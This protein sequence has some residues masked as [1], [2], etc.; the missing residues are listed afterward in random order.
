MAP[1]PFKP[2]IAGMF[3]M[4]AV[5]AA[6]LFAHFIRLAEIEQRERREAFNRNAA[7]EN[8]RRWKERQKATEEKAQAAAKIS[9]ARAQERAALE[10]AYAKRQPFDVG[11]A[12]GK[13]RRRAE[14][15][16]PDAQ[17][18]MGYIHLHG[19]DHV[20]RVDPQTFGTSGSP[21]HASALIG[22]DIQ[23]LFFNT[24]FGHR[25]AQASLATAYTY[26]PTTA[27]GQT[28]GYM[29][30]LLANQQA[31]PEGYQSRDGVTATSRQRCHD[32]LERKLTDDQKAAARKAAAAFRPYKEQPAR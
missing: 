28:N 15:G 21:K 12:F 13:L 27:A 16:D 10:A 19:M 23:P 24:R 17:T 2:L 5:A 32:I 1:N 7:A 11:T 25:D 22:Q 30:S 29:W 4:L 18:L 14:S 26:G 3:V 20:L 6:T 9:A 8:E 31:W